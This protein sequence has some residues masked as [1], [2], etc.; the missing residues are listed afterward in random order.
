MPVY[1]FDFFGIFY[2]LVHVSKKL[3]LFSYTRS[4]IY[5]NLLLI[6]VKFHIRGKTQLT[7]Y[8]LNYDNLNKSRILNNFGFFYGIWNIPEYRPLNLFL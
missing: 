2:F 7:F 4:L 1:I 6:T 5:L 3:Y 8:Y